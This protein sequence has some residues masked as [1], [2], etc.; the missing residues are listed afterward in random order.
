MNVDVPR[1]TVY[2]SA[3]VC[4]VMLQLRN[5]PVGMCACRAQN[6]HDQSA[7]EFVASVAR[8]AFESPSFGK[9]EILLLVRSYYS[10]ALLFIA[11]KF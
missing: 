1:G 11:I 10:T 8:K 4:A 7:T 5:Y 6:P 3:K 9:C 2:T